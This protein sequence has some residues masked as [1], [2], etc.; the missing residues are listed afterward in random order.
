[1]ANVAMTAEIV[2]RVVTTT[3]AVQSF[4]V[5]VIGTK[6]VEVAESFLMR[7]IMDIR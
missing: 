2:A 7:W 5:K 6:N 4:P 1:M 3:A